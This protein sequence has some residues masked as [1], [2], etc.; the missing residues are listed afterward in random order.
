M[1]L[2]FQPSL[3]ISVT[4]EAYGL[5]LIASRRLDAYTKELQGVIDRSNLRPHWAKYRFTIL[6]HRCTLR[7]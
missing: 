3:R 2:G 6:E 5:E 4:A 7:S 1:S